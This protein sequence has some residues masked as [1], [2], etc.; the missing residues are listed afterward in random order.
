MPTTLLHMVQDYS[1]K[2]VV[3]TKV[4]S[5]SK[6]ETQKQKTEKVELIIS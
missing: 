6:Q 3:D 1:N 5:A 4:F 2:T